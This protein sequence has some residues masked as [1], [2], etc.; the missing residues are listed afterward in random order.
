[1]IVRWLKS[2][3]MALTAPWHR[4]VLNFLTSQTTAR[5]GWLVSKI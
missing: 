3:T 4:C 2:L 1:M 5:G